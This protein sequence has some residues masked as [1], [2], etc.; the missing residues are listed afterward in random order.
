M[1]HLQ[2][3]STSQLDAQHEWMTKPVGQLVKIGEREE[4]IQR[5]CSGF[6]ISS[7]NGYFLTAG[8]C[9]NT[10]N[11]EVCYLNNPDFNSKEIRVSFTYEC[12]KNT[13]QGSCYVSEKEPTYKINNVIT[14]GYCNYNIAERLD[15]AVLQLAPDAARYKGLQLSMSI[16][17]NEHRIAVVQHPAGKHKQ[18]STGIIQPS[19]NEGLINHTAHTLG[20]SS[21]SP[22]ISLE[23]NKVVAIHVAGSLSPATKMKDQKNHYA[24]PI[25]NII[26]TEKKNGKTW[27]N[28]IGLFRQPNRNSNGVVNIL[29][30]ANAA[31][32]VSRGYAARRFGCC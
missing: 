13:G 10:S 24:V 9:L 2:F 11:N 7:T 26:E 20:G 22:V 18:I 1:T 25:K 23:E 4:I 8:H 17:K 28:N 14:Q 21:G 31:M 19:Q 12:E 15:Y 3:L 16:P 29:N 32:N 27:I 30:D 5:F 6:N